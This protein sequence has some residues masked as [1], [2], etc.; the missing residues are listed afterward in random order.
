MDLIPAQTVEALRAARDDL[1]TAAARSARLGTGG[2]AAA[3]GAMALA[4]SRAIFADALLAAAKARLDA[5]KG[6]TR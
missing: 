1:Q 6:V 2:G 5:L 3:Q 4:A